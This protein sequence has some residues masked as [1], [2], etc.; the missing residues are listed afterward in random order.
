MN[1]YQQQSN[2]RTE[3]RPNFNESNNRNNN[4][5]NIER[6]IVGPD[7]PPIA[8]SRSMSPANRPNQGN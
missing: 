7:Q 6:G 2:M 1:N 8:R 3:S 4:N 5:N